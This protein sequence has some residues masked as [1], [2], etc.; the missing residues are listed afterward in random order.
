MKQALQKLLELTFHVFCLL[1][2]FRLIAPWTMK[3]RCK[4]KKK[5]ERWCWFDENET[6]KTQ[7]TNMF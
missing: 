5:K 7:R 4:K 6:D 2:R 3:E 1:K